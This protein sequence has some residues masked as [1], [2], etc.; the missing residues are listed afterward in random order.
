MRI[1]FVNKFGNNKCS[2]LRYK[3]NFALS[4]SQVELSNGKTRVLVKPVDIYGRPIP[5]NLLLIP[6]IKGVDFMDVEPRFIEPIPIQYKRR[7]IGLVVG[8]SAGF[9]SVPPGKFGWGWGFG[10]TLGYRIF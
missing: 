9:Y 10:L 6:F 4:L 3:M 2:M 5:D 1:K 8:P 7:V